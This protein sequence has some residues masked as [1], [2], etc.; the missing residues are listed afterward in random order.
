MRL[1]FV[2]PT[3]NL[4][5]GGGSNFSFHLTASGLAR[6]GHD[7]RVVIL[8]TGRQQTPNDLPYQ[9]INVAW[10]RRAQLWSA[11][12][13]ADLLRQFSSDTEIFH[14]YAPSLALGG[15]F[16]KAGGGRTPVVVTLNNYQVFCT[17]AAIMD[18]HCFRH[19]GVINRVL[20]SPSSPARKISSLPFRLYEQWFGFKYVNL[21]DH[22]LPLTPAVQE[23][24]AGAGFDMRRSTVIP[25]VI[26]YRSMRGRV[27]GLPADRLRSATGT[28]H[29]LFAGRLI[30]AKGADLLV[31]ALPHL[32]FPA[33]LHIAGDGPQIEALR[34][35]VR[36]LRQESQVTFHGWVANRELWRLYRQVDVFVHPGRWPEPCGRTIQEAMTI[37]VPTI[38]S[39]IGGPPWVLGN[40]GRTF[41]PG[42]PV[43]LAEKLNECFERYDEAWEI[44][45]RAY[46]RA[47]E[48]DFSRAVLKLEEVYRRLLEH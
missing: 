6:V 33:H 28:W 12:A 32:R 26:D 7:V 1:T 41:R 20:H 25:A 21:L 5:T 40:Y 16:Y 47:A 27:A 17:Y 36:A 38:V 8:D 43:D 15:G 23:I 48:F 22:F 13:V 37:G 45:I 14:L 44:A 34:A 35:R 10:K 4:S 46:E 30:P 18:E 31:E 24:Y 9:V 19:C 42:D 2:V 39:D 11:R 3:I 29:I